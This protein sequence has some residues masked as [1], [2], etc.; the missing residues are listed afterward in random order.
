M[1]ENIGWNGAQCFD[2]I[3]GAFW[4][5]PDG[6]QHLGIFNARNVANTDILRARETRDQ[7]HCYCTFYYFLF[8][9]LTH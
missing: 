1:S 3:Q 4:H 7:A 2:K 8:Y 5:Y 6:I 9:L